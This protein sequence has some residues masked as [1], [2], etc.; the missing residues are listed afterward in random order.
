MAVS[1][2]LPI[3]CEVNTD[4]LNEISIKFHKDFD[5]L[6]LEIVNLKITRRIF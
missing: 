2:N 6:K 4:P 1:N 5:F 3:C